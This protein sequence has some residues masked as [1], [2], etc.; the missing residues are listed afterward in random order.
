MRRALTDKAALGVLVGAV[1]IAFSGILYRKS[2]VS[3]VTGAFYRCFWALPFLWALVVW[4]ERRLGPRPRALRRAAWIGGAFFAADLILWHYAIEKVGAGLATVLGNTQV[5]L[6]G[7]LAWVLFR[8]R[9][10]RN[11]LMAIP[12]AMAG[13]CSSRVFW[14]TAPT[15]ATRSSAR[16]SGSSPES[17]IGLPARVPTGL[18]RAGRVAGPLFDAT[19]ATTVFV[20]PAGLVLGDLDFTPSLEATLWLLALALSSQVVGWLLITVSLGRLPAARTSVLLT[21]QPLLAVLFAALLIDERPSPLQLVGAGFILSGLLIASMG[22]QQPAPLETV[23]EHRQVRHSRRRTACLDSTAWQKLRL[24]TSP[25]PNAG[26]RPAAGSGAVRAAP[27]SARSPSKRRRLQTGTPRPSRCFASPRWRSRMP[28]GSRP[29]CPSSTACSAAGSCRPRSFSSGGEPGV[30]KSTLL[31]MALAAISRERRALLVTGEESTAQ[32][33]LRAARLGGAE[34]VEI[35]AETNLEVVCATLERERPDVCVIDSIQTLYSAEV[36]SAPGSVSQVREAAA[37]LLR[38]GKESGVALFLV[39]H[40]FEV[41]LGED[42]DLLGATEPRSAKL[43]LRGRLLA[44]HEQGP[45]LARDRSESHQR[46]RRLPT[47][48]SPPDEDE[49]GRTSHRRA[50]G[51]ARARRSGSARH[52]RPPRRRGGAAG[53]PGLPV[54]AGAA[55]SASVPKLA[56]LGQ[57]PSQ[58]PVEYPHSEQEKCRAAAFAMPSSLGTRSDADCAE[59]VPNARAPSRA[60][61]AAAVPS[62]R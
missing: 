23:P 30:G 6:V 22:R 43:H 42:L 26:T 50:R 2:N 59:S 7:L 45:P 40:D 11:A 25:A 48:G 36:G 24:C 27:A 33:K 53:W 5:V 37:R 4:E 3:P 61:P 35:L 14:R 44:G 54:G 58:R 57:R 17:P 9:L 12:V 55:C 10:S 34:Q 47:P 8:E 13:S 21:L 41:R 38:V 39:G 20:V 1:A 52:P 32:V 56:Q 60:A 18:R 19:L 28:S 49:R 46:R 15:E 29:A 31:L 16:S 62:K 51:R